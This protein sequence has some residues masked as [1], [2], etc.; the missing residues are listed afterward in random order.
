[1]TAEISDFGFRIFPPSHGT[2]GVAGPHGARGRSRGSR[3]RRRQW[4]WAA[5][6]PAHS[7]QRHRGWRSLQVVQTHPA[8]GRTTKTPRHQ[9]VHEENPWCF[10]WCLGAFVV[11]TV[12]A[13]ASEGNGIRLWSAR[14]G[15][16]AVAPPAHCP[17]R[18][19]GR[20]PLTLKLSL[21]RSL[22]LPLRLSLSSATAT[23]TAICCCH[24][25]PILATVSVIRTRTRTR[26]R[27]RVSSTSA[28][29]AIPDEPNV[30]PTRAGKMPAPPWHVPH[31]GAPGGAGVSPALGATTLTMCR[32][33]ACTT[34]RIAFPTTVR[35]CG[36]GVSPALGATT[37]TMCRRD[38]CTT[39]R[40]VL[41]C[42]PSWRWGVRTFERF[43]VQRLNVLPCVSS[44]FRG[45]AWRRCARG[46]ARPALR[47]MR[48]RH[49]SPPR[50][51]RLR[52]ARRA[53]SVRRRGSARRPR[54]RGRR[55][56]P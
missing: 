33:D 49:R 23:A 44:S 35:N 20:C 27:T 52:A 31:P 28:S 45:R 9:D 13:D 14:L 6:T 50:R 39:M 51:C 43:N 55:P 40:R 47:T 18:C 37:L 56:P 21:K 11:A 48:A 26:T 1:M 19:H 22:Q 36:A 16:V 2:C 15:H 30:P 32:R 7:T 25:T 46:C 10:S 5:A 3:S 17:G 29:P 38:A 12:R 4:Q 24:W 54:G 53:A 41:Q 34:M 8:R 42:P